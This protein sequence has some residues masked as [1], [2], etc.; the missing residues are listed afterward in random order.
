MKISKTDYIGYLNCRKNTWLKIHKRELYNSYPISAFD[1][2]LTDMGNTV[3]EVARLKFPK[4]ILIQGRGLAEQEQTKKLIEEKA[5]VIFQAV[6]AT[7][8]FLMASDVLK[9]N[10]KTD[11]YDLYEIKMSSADN[12]EDSENDNSSKNEESYLNDLAFQSIVL[13]ACSVNIGQKYLV[14]INKNYIKQGEI[15]PEKLFIEQN[16]TAEVENLK[17]AVNEKM[18]EAYRYLNEEDEPTGNCDCYYKGRNKHCTT[19]QNSNPTVPKYSVHDLNRIGNSP[20]LLEKLLEN[21]SLEIS[22]IPED[23]EGLTPKPTKAKPDPK[24]RKLNQIKTHKTQKPI[25]DASSIKAELDSLKF[26]LYFLDYETYPTA[27]P[28]F[29][30]YRPYQQIVFQYSLHTLK[31]ASSQLEH[32]EFIELNNDPAKN[33][34]ESLKKEIGATGTILVWHKPFENTR[35]KEIGEMLPEYKGFFDSIIERTY[36]LKDIVENQYFVHP[37]FMGRSSI[38]YVLPALFPEMDYKHLEVKSGTDAIEAYRQILEGEILG[39]EVEK[40]KEA[41]LRYCERDTEAM[42]KVWEYFKNLVA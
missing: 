27:I 15:E 35:A 42:V 29:D 26:P 19:F 3:E 14:E 2:S 24:P 6:F 17:D 16:K 30:G 33:F 36:D 1:K 10:T 41:M 22:E 40:K 18:Q 4:G 25:I 23:T 21:G 34:A 8:C 37:K 7:D 39:Q 9:F 12:S 31:T 32:S 5:E 28:I 13:E 20:K 38:K 11:C